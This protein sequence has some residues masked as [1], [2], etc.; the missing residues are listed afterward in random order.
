MEKTMILTTIVGSKLHG[1]DN[2]D[3]DTD[4]RGV[5]IVPLN[6]FLSPFKEVKD[7]HWVEGEDTD[8]TAYEL[9]KFCKMAAQGNPSCLEVLVGLPQMSTPLGDEL[10]ALLPKFLSKKRCYE[11][12]RGYSR[13]QEKKM[14]E[15]GEVKASSGAK[16]RRWKYASAHIRTMYQLLH[17]LKT[18]ELVGRLP[19]GEVDEI[20]KYKNGFGDI[21]DFYRRIT[22]LEE[23]CF[24]ELEKSPLPES[25]DIPAIENFIIR[26]YS[27]EY[28]R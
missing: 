4:L 19:Q 15:G 1:T 8:D 22:Q 9:T 11:A 18:G 6:T 5:F 3:S 25:A 2:P 23:L 21:G 12:F 27:S 17:L 24:D 7:A 10:K 20:R 16:D 26:A 14:R 28:A 13:N